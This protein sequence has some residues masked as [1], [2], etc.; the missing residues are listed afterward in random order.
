[1]GKF[2]RITSTP[3]PVNELPK[4]EVPMST[5]PPKPDPAPVTTAPKVLVANDGTIVPVQTDVAHGFVPVAV[6]VSV[7][8]SGS[9]AGYSF[10][11]YLM[12]NKEGIKII[13]GATFG[14]ASSLLGMV[15]NVGL[16]ALL[17]IVIGTASKFALDAIDFWLTAVPV[18]PKV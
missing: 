14:Y 17:A 13:V 6:P 16:N 18:P 3:I 11:A 7:S 2:V 4:V 12:R 5:T 1:M 15:K 9:F 8:P 10:R